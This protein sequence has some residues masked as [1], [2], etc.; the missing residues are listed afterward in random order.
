MA[1]KAPEA[2][3][4]K[5]PMSPLGKALHEATG[6]VAQREHAEDYYAKKDAG[7]KK[8]GGKISSASSRADGVAQRGKTRGKMK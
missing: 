2:K 8:K 3:E 5:A 6:S 4:F 7:G 1:T